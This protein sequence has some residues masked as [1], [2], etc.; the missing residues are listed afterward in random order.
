[1]LLTNP[2]NSLSVRR[3]T[4]AMSFFLSRLGPLTGAVA[5]LSWIPLGGSPTT[6]RRVLLRH[7]ACAARDGKRSVKERKYHFVSG[8]A[9]EGR[10]RGS[11]QWVGAWIAREFEPCSTAKPDD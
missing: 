4:F 8:A 7:S 6:Q 11:L 9:I 5:S 3:G 2:K 10:L 1:M